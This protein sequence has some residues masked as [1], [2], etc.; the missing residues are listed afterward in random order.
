MSDDHLVFE[1]VMYTWEYEEVHKII[2]CIQYPRL[3]GIFTKD[4]NQ[5]LGKIIIMLS[6]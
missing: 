2:L 4:E 3:L 5:L 1:I 6:A